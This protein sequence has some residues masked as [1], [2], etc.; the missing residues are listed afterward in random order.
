MNFIFS[1]AIIFIAEYGIQHRSDIW[2]DPDKFNPDRFGPN[3]KIAPFT[4]M[5]FTAGPRICI[6]KHFAM[7]EM[8]ILISRLVKEFDIIDADPGND[9]LIKL[10]M[11]TVKPKFGVFVNLKRA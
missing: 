11:L 9:V 8:K 6:G 7:M 1:D 2:E 5:P 10:K 3:K 4:F